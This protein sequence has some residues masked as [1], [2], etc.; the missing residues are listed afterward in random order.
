L[1]SGHAISWP[2]SGPPTGPLLPTILL[3]GLVDA[4]RART[5]RLFVPEAARR[6]DERISDRMR[7]A[8]AILE[9]YN[10]HVI[11]Q[12]AD[13]LYVEFPDNLGDEERERMF[14]NRCSSQ[15]SEGLRVVPVRRFDALASLGPRV[16]VGKVGLAMV[17][18]LRSH[19]TRATEQFVRE[20]HARALGLIL[21]TKWNRLQSL[22]A[23][24]IRR[25]RARTWHVGDFCRRET[26]TESL[27]EY[28]RT[29][30]GK[31]RNPAAAYEALLRADE[32][33][34]RERERIR[35]HSSG[36]PAEESQRTQYAAGTTVVYYVAGT[37]R[38]LSVADMSRLAEFW[39]P[40]APDENTDYYVDRLR[41]ATERY[42]PLLEE[43]D[44]MRIFSDE[45]LFPFQDRD[46]KPLRTAFSATDSGKPPSVDPPGIWLDVERA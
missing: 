32:A 17:H 35:G 21:E 4:M 25:I 39:D 28:V 43:E 8:A 5:S 15:F 11:Q 26:L 30:E 2:R 40:S 20:Y 37:R 6:L 42:R 14:W 44:F 12:T 38:D 41:Q 9:T 34:Q 18:L 29:K 19:Q 27:E 3:T 7:H 13:R 24:S 16:L 10:V 45:S 46:I 36:T 23:E 22:T 31:R 33:Y 1:D